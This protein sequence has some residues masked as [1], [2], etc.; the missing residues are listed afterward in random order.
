MAPTDPSVRKVRLLTA[1]LLVATFAA[2]TVT[3]AGVCRWV[4]PP[5]REAP[6][7]PPPGGPLPLEELG[8][9]AEQRDKAFAILERH[10]PELEAVLRETFPKVRA[11]NALIESEIRQLLTAEQAKKLDE[12]QA[13]RPPPPPGGP[14]PGGPPPGGPPPGGPPPGFFAPPS[15][16]APSAPPPSP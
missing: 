6:P 13:R 11:I 8:L 12:I 1:L 2:G 16:P 15:G 7:P 14:H 3:G 10:R 5:R 4:A 9:S